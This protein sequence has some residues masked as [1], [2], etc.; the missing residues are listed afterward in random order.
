M[1]DILQAVTLLSHLSKRIC[2][3]HNP[4]CANLLNR[5][6]SVSGYEKVA[7]VIKTSEGL[8]DDPNSAALARAQL[9]AWETNDLIIIGA[10]GGYCVQQTIRGALALGEAVMP[11]SDVEN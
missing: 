3:I 1:P 9:T 8:F 4:T 5:L 6:S 2:R 10:N 7:S 11:R